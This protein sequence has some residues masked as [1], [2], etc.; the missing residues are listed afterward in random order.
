MAYFNIDFNQFKPSTKGGVK[1]NPP[2]PVVQQKQPIPAP[3]QSV[4]PPVVRSTP[5]QQPV[6]QSFVGQNPTPPPVQQA[7]KSLGMKVIDALNY[8]SMKAEQILTGGKGYD[9]RL[10]QAGIKNTPGQLD[11]NDVISNAG[12][13]VIDPLNFLPVGKIA[14]GAGALLSK[15][16]DA[17]R[18]AKAVNT[19][20]DFA[21]ET[22]IVKNLG[23]KFVKGYGLP[24]TYNIAK[25]EIPTKLGIGAKNIIEKTTEQFGKPNNSIVKLITGKQTSK[26]TNDVIEAIPKFLEPRGAGKSTDLKLLKQTIEDTHGVGFFE[27]EVRPILK[28]VSKQFDNDIYDLVQRGRL[29]GAKAKELLTQGGYYPHM[30][31]APERIKEYFAPAKVLSEK[32]GYLTKRKGVEGFTFNAPK[33]IS[34]REMAQFHDNVIQDFFKGV[35][36]QFGKEIAQGDTIPEGFKYVQ[37]TNGRLQELSGWALPER[38]AKDIDETFSPASGLG[39]LVDKFNA[40]WKPTA[41]SVNPSFHVMNIV[42]NLYNTWLGG[43]KDPRRFIQAVRGVT[44]PSE[45]AILEASGVLARGQFGADV[46]GRTFDNPEGLKALKIIEPFRKTGEIFENNARSAFFLDQRAKAIKSG[47]D[48]VSANRVALQKVNEYLFDYLTGLTPFETNVMRRVFP[49]Y[50]WARFNIPLQLKSIITQPGKVA[51][52]AKIQRMFNQE[53]FLEGDQEGITFPTPFQDNQGRPV[54]FKPNLPI[55]DIFSL[56]PAKK[57]IQMLNPLIKESAQGLQYAATGKYQDYFTGKEIT[58]SNLPVRTQVG[59][60]IRSR[61]TALLR[62]V[63]SVQ[64]AGEEDF[65]PQGILRQIIGGTYTLDPSQV[66]MTKIYNENSK[67]AA[68]QNYIQKIMRDNSLTREERLQK[69]KEF[70]QYS[71]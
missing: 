26:L 63:R 24:A 47:M 4:A 55:Q 44:D 12:R 1:I 21:K 13:M 6:R 5:A 53:G 52:V 46:V 48:E 41:T 56:N 71:Q 29:G 9:Q 60:V 67:N 28:D 16:D 49:F 37:H 3:T 14:K 39:K 62:P 33:A 50:T 2:T 59:D 61:T 19:A 11:M 15:A 10:N 32:R 65:S 40:A 7:D 38:I 17:G 54:R 45:K 34:K 58:N 18:I 42:G 69:I 27:K 64:K 51:A 66:E 57:M 22:P 25:S 68:L 43:M 70:Q 23:E 31:F 8:P 35:K 30:D 20:A 36:T